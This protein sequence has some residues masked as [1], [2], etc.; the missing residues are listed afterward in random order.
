MTDTPETETAVKPRRRWMGPLLVASLA[1]NLLVL[2]AMAG[3][4]FK[5]GGPHGP[6]GGGRHGGPDRI[7]WLLPDDKRDGARAI[8][9]RYRANEG[10]REAEGKVARDAVSAALTSEPF[11]QPAFEAAL[12]RA[13]EAEIGRRL[14]PKMLAEIAATLSLDERKE[15]AEH[16]GR[17]M[18]RRKRWGRKKS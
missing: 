9:E 15:L 17:L 18:E 12:K 5:H 14:D 3:W 10:A 8:I 6:W 13:G 16:L 11:S 2:G 4:A 7:L 1:L